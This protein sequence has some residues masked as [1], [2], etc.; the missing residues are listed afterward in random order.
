MNYEEKVKTFS[1]GE[2]TLL[3]IFAIPKDIAEVG[4]LLVVGGPQYRVGSHRQFLQLSRQLASAGIPV[5]RFDYR[6][7]GDSEGEARNFEQVNEDL[8]S[9]LSTFFLEVPGLKKVVVWGLCD[10]A[11]CILMNLTSDDRIKSLVLAN[12]WVRTEATLANAMVKHYYK[13]RVL[14]W[15]FWKKV[16]KGNFDLKAS[17]KSFLQ[18][19][20]SRKKTSSASQTVLPFPE[21]MALG[22]KRFKGP[23]MFMISGQDITAKEFE[24]LIK[25]SST[26]QQAI[27]SKQIEWRRIEE[28]THTFSSQAWREQVGL[29]TIDWV[30]SI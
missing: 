1:C 14:Q 27:S 4:V 2:D 9:A 20:N 13:S 8:M 18:N 30:K 11:S 24:D 23:V 5:M 15:E 28:A 7:M 21:Q 12:P 26:W 29:W 6:G 17:L 19:L 25:S 3:G 22:L 10:A 16:I